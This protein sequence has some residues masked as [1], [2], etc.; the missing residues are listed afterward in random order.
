[1]RRD[2]RLRAYVGVVLL[3]AGVVALLGVGSGPS[4]TLRLGYV[5]VASAW[6]VVGG[7][8]LERLPGHAIGRVMLGFGTMMAAYVVSDVLIARDPTAPIAAVLAWL[9]GQLDGPLFLAVAL[10]FLF[11]PTGLPPSPR[12]RIL[13]WVDVIM[14]IGVT[15]GSAFRPGP[16]AYYPAIVNPFA[17]EG[18]SLLGI[19][20]PAYLL[21]VGSVAISALSIIGR[22][23]TG[24]PVERAQ[25]K[26]VAAAA[27]VV[28]ITMAAYAILF[29]PGRYNDIADLSVGLAFG[30][31]AA[32]IGI[33]ILR[34]RLFEIDRIVS[35]T[36][37]Y[38]VVTAA[39]LASYAGVILLLQGPLGS[40][41]G[42]E[43]IP[44]A[45]STLVVAALF[46]PLRRRVQS[47]VDRR[48]D[49]A[50]FDAERASSAFA[51][52]LREQVD[53]D[54]VTSDL[55]ATVDAALRPTAMTLWVRRADA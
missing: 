40:M 33:A 29:G 39:L 18:F 12:W 16:F 32:A 35:R 13:V 30:S 27:A 15:I 31:F 34:Y 8:V 26:W 6:L 47:L 7:L 19:W 17:I 55:R 36:I 14:A 25:L 43:T 28:A 1:M 9:V 11:F 45:I 38:L 4:W 5:G 53:I 10:L 21:L 24:G 37:A 20:E 41:T 52:R 48:F 42:G 44:V 50:R 3:T 2:R 51:E 22:W 54:A 46:Q 23:R 49:R